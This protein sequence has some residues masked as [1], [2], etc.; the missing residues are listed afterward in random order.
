MTEDKH[1][2]NRELRQELRPKAL[3]RAAV[4]LLGLFAVTAMLLSSGQMSDLRV[5]LPPLSRAMR[6]LEGLPG[7]FDMDHVAFFALLA[8]A[9]RVLLPR[10]RW[11]WLLAGF[12]VLAAGTEL[13][14]FLTIGRTPKLEDARDD[15]LGAGIGLLLG[16]IPFWLV[17]VAG[18]LRG[19]VH[20]QPTRDA[21]AGRGV[22]G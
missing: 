1:A 13:L 15:M 16:S 4:A 2:L 14:Q 12:A 20:R 7:P 3:T 10:V 9:L 8:G 17:R 6:W 18:R 5:A 11:W 21:G 19:L 22:G